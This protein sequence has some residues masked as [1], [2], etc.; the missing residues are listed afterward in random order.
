[1]CN[2]HIFNKLPKSI[3]GR[4]GQKMFSKSVKDHYDNICQ[5]PG[6]LN[7]CKSCK[8]PAVR[9]P[10]ERETRKINDSNLQI[11]R[12]IT[13]TE[14]LAIDI[15][16]HDPFQKILKGLEMNEKLAVESH[17]FH[18]FGILPKM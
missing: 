17:L 9:P 6:N 14:K 13:R 18:M 11:F 4:L 10:D 3:R 8:T 15:Y 2:A 16:L 12:E 7:S 1:M 5:H